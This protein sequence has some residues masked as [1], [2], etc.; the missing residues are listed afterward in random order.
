MPPLENNRF[1]GRKIDPDTKILA[2]EYRQ[3]C[4]LDILIESWKWEGIRG[5]S[6]I[7]LS[8]QVINVIDSEFENLGRKIAELGMEEQVTI[9]RG[10]DFSFFNFSFRT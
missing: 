4:G 5:K 1:S 9:K 7:F 2:T 6:I 8:E 3:I 10:P